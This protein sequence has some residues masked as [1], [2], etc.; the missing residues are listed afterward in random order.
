MPVSLQAGFASATKTDP[1]S[2]RKGIAALGTTFDS[3]VT[4]GGATKFGPTRFDGAYQVRLLE[5]DP[6]TKS[7][8][9][10][11]GNTKTITIP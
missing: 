11:E 9:P 3:S 6:S 2:L 7:F 4:Y 1:A 10:M 5:F 8:P